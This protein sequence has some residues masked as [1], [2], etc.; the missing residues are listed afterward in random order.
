[1]A[2]GG[3][4]FEGGSL[5][6]WENKRGDQSYLRTQKGRSLKTLGGFREGGGVC[7]ENERVGSGGDRESHQKLLGVMT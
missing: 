2:R 7:L 3:G 6:F 1:M 4:G 5:D